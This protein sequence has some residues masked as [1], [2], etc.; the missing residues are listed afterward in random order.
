MTSYFY[1]NLDLPLHQSESPCFPCCLTPT[2]NLLTY[3]YSKQVVV[4]KQSISQSGGSSPQNALVQVNGGFFFTC[5]VYIV[6]SRRRQS[7]PLAIIESKPQHRYTPILSTELWLLIIREATATDPNPLD[8]SRTVSFLDPSSSPHELARYRSSMRNK[9][10][11]S[12]DSKIWNALLQEVL[13]EFVWISCASQ[14]KALAHNLLLCADQ[15]GRYIRRLHIET[16]SLV[17][18]D[19]LDL[20]TILDHAPK[21]IVYSDH[22]SVRRSRYDELCAPR[23]SPEQL[24]SA[25]AHPENVL[26]RLSWTSYDDFSFHFLVSPMLEKTAAHLEYLE[27]SFCSPHLPNPSSSCYTFVPITLPA[28]RSLKVTLDNVMFTVL[29]SWD[30]PLLR[31]LSVISADFSYASRGFS[32]F[33]RVHGHKIVQLELGHS[34]SSIE[35]HYLTMPPHVQHLT[36]QTAIPLAEWCPNLREF[37][38]S[39]DAEWNWQTPDWIAPHVLL[40]THGR[41]ELIGIRDIDKRLMD[42]AAMSF[43]ASTEDDA[44]FFPLL[45]Q[46]SSLL[47]SEAFPS[48]RYVR[49]L[50]EGSERMR[51]RAT[52]VRVLKFWTKVLRRCRE[53]E[54]WLED[55]TGVNVTTR[56]LKRVGSS[57][58]RATRR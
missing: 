38:C 22:H 16:P 14:G 35:E 11:L 57:M 48:L 39:A 50:S 51:K 2:T 29:S 20:R 43:S 17:R 23:A 15:R 1:I 34:S 55:W 30:M 13:Y 8:T 31:N 28:L 21:L 24:F 26:R 56:D 3:M 5:L 52:Q 32:N 19:P 47:R 49:D 6:D 45:E 46:L 37:I 25:L 10:R 54:V 44:V 7:L 12:F 40:P 4:N 27:L 58:N 9:C 18:C 36:Q 41:L 53:R 42:D 33:F